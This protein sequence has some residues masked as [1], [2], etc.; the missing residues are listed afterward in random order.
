MLAQCF[1]GKTIAIHIPAILLCDMPS[2]TG[3]CKTRNPPRNPQP[4]PPG[5][6]QKPPGNCTG[7]PGLAE[8]PWNPPEPPGTSIKI[9]YFSILPTL[10]LHLHDERISKNELGSGNKFS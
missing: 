4:E 10:F 9:Y 3:V 2:G 6:P 5:T 8:T 7:T 1:P